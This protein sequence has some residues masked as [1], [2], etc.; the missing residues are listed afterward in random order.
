MRC[1]HYDLPVDQQLPV[2]HLR[3]SDTSPTLQHGDT[4]ELGPVICWNLAAETIHSLEDAAGQEARCQSH[5]ED[6]FTYIFYTGQNTEYK[7]GE[8]IL[9][10]E[11]VEIENCGLM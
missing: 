8:G 7:Q 9:I 2:Q 5:C 11:D 10:I 3:T 6:D 4:C 1:D